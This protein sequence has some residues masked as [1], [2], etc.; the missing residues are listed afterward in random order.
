MQ[1]KVQSV[2]RDEILKSE[3]EDALES[4]KTVS[5]HSRQ[6]FVTT[7]EI[8]IQKHGAEN[9]LAAALAVLSGRGRNP[10]NEAV[11]MDYD[12]RDIRLGGDV[13]GR[14]PE[15]KFPVKGD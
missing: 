4:L 14:R 13:R 12:R 3:A 10:E 6:P 8:M 9:A 15:R 11:Q 1:F 5:S 7:A 2:Q